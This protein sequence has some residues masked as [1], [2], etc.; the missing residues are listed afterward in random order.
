MTNNLIELQ[1]VKIL[2]S[3]PKCGA[4]QCIEQPYPG[5]HSY[6]VTYKCGAKIVIAGYGKEYY[7]YDEEC[8]NSFPMMEVCPK[9]EEL[10]IERVEELIMESHDPIKQVI[11]MRKDLKMRKG[12]IAAQ[13]AHASMKVFFDLMEQCYEDIDYPF[14]GVTDSREI[15][16]KYEIQMT[17]EMD[18]WKRGAFTKIT[19]YVNSEEELLDLYY[20]A[21]E[22]ELP[23]AL[24]QDSGR[25]EFNGVPTHTCIAIGPARSTKINKITGNLPLY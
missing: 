12:K 22:G 13:A 3:C 18:E 1:D 5:T 24:I 15:E 14:G 2:R 9:D 16:G 23:T 4:E 19:V 21:K 17:P 7:S 8:S 20:Q 11:V 25:T 6:T 10:S